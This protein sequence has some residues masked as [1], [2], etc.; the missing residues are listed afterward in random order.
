MRPSYLTLFLSFLRL[1]LTAFGGPAMVPYIRRMA[2]ERRSWLGEGTFRLGVGLAQSVPGATAMQVA[3]YVG[4]R[5]RGVF[6][7]LAA[8]LG[9][10]LPAFLMV[11][12]LS[13]VYVAYG[14]AGP[15]LRAFAG[16]RVVMVALM[17]SA[18]VQFTRR[19]CVEWRDWLLGAVA[20][21]WFA[22][23][24]NPIVILVGACAAAM[25]LYP[26]KAPAPERAGTP[27]GAARPE[28]H[29]AGLAALAG[30]LALGLAVLWFVD[31]NLFDLSVLMAKIDLF[32]FG[33]GYVSLPLMLHEV[34]EAHGWMS[35]AMFMDGIAMGQLTPGPIVMTAT[36]VGYVGHG[37][38]GAIAATVY[39]FAPSLLIVTAMVPFADRLRSSD[40]FARALRGSLVTLAGLLVA[41]SGRFGLAVDWSVAGAAIAVAGFVLL[42]RGADILWVVLGGGAAALLLL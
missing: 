27:G 40:L 3:A 2:V 20:C 29:G 17:A 31:R 39:V 4:F 36:F 19:Y 22:L 23:G 38:A 26:D 15:V 34:V 9:F 30:A 41:V 18:A 11:L 13:W 10:G 16:L 37:L 5:T 6:G 7:A 8:Y 24:L 1:G 32:A 33:G 12:A 35:E 14:D 25:R 28:R 42:L 21:A